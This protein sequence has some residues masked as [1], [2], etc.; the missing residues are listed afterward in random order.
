MRKEYRSI[1]SREIH[2]LK[3]FVIG[4]IMILLSMLFTMLIANGKEDFDKIIYWEISF[5]VLMGFALFNSIFSYSYEKK[6]SY[7]IISLAS[8]VFLA[9]FGGFASYYFSGIR[10]DDADS[11]KW[12]YIVFTFSY[13]VFISIVN[14]MRTII[15]LVKK[16]DARLRGEE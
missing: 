6:S 15:E 16:Q 14:M 13:L 2:P 12:L 11:F 9:L 7:F 5:A 4:L 1:F 8:Y 10:L 3:Q